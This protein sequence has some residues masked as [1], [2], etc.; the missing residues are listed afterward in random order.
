MSTTLAEYYRGHE[1][2]SRAIAAHA[3]PA[4]R[5]RAVHEAVAPLLRDTDAHGELACR[6]GCAHCCHFPVGVTF[7]EAVRLSEAVR[8]DPRLRRRVL[9][10][11]ASTASQTW[12]ELV[13]RPCPLL[14]DGA[15]ARYAERP[16]PCRALGSRDADACAASLTGDVPVPRDEHAFWRGL[17]AA[18]ALAQGPPAGHRELR[19]ALAALLQDGHDTPTDRFTHARPT[20]TP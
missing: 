10:E 5:A 11:A 12:S 19:S 13:A 20:P 2:A 7:A 16:L 18:A 6:S 3:T 4:E 14:V 1:R 15:C 8:Q 17:G 9:D